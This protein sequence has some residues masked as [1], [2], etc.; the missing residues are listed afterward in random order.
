MS[1]FL[2][3]N[4]SILTS[5]NCMCFNS[6]H[7]YLF[8]INAF[9]VVINDIHGS[10]CLEIWAILTLL[11]QPSH[12]TA[13]LLDSRDQPRKQQ[14]QKRMIRGFNVWI[15]T[16]AKPAFISTLRSTVFPGC[17]R[18][19]L[20]TWGV[21]RVVVLPIVS[22]IWAVCTSRVSNWFSNLSINAEICRERKIDLLFHF[23]CMLFVCLHSY[24]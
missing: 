17:K 11:H 5:M 10:D 18:T 3:M 6:P 15:I 21:V 23:V 24:T 16:G 9:S 13:C 7:L 20:I 1:H 14:F 19:V 22:S 4:L 2:K 8:F 12:A